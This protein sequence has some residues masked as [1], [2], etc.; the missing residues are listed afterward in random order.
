MLQLNC[1]AETE[2]KGGGDQR[3][4]RVTDGVGRYYSLLNVVTHELELRYLYPQN[5]PVEDVKN[6][7]MFIK[8]EEWYQAYLFAYIQSNTRS[9]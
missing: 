3:S 2:S 7:W 5:I 1:T 8:L 6:V 4:T 9:T